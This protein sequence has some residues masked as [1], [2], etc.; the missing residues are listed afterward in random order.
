MTKDEIKDK[1]VEI[2]CKQ[3]EQPKEK[4]TMET[5]FAED[6]GAD[7][8]DTAELV[9]EFEDE[10]DINISDDAEGKIKTVGDTVSY[11]EEQIKKKG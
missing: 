11:I 9:M 7:S 8:L 2:I 3:L 1:V 5:K 6:L 4:V 10:F